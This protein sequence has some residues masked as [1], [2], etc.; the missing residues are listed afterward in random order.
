MGKI[1]LSYGH[2]TGMPHP[3]D[4]H[5]GRRVRMR[6]TLLGMSQTNLGE[7]IG[8]TFQQIQKYERG[9]N[10]I[11]SSRLFDLCQALDVPIAFFFEDMPAAVASSSRAHGGGMAEELSHYKL[12]PMA[13]RE[14]LE[15]VR[16]YYRISSPNVRKRLFELTKAFA[17]A[18]VGMT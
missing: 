11:G 7:A 14:S 2:G 12:D 4:V 3:V 1:R 16:A 10:R 17:A 13:K 9:T 18:S 5:V 6:R 8:L 15:L